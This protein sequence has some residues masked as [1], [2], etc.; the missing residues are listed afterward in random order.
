METE[1]SQGGNPVP[2]GT[3]ILHEE[4]NRP[5]ARRPHEVPHLG[6]MDN[7]SEEAKEEEG[8]SSLAQCLAL[9]FVEEER[10]GILSNPVERKTST[11]LEISQRDPENRTGL[12]EEN[13]NVPEARVEN[14]SDLSGNSPQG[15]HTVAYSPSG[16][17]SPL[18][19]TNFLS[20]K[21]RVIG[22]VAAE[23]AKAQA[24]L[25]VFPQA[26]NTYDTFSQTLGEAT[27]GTDSCHSPK[28][29]SCE[30]FLGSHDVSECFPGSHDVS[31]HHQ[32]AESATFR[33]E[34]DPSR[35]QEVPF[36]MDKERSQKMEATEG[37]VEKEPFKARE[38]DR[39]NHNPLTR[40]GEEA[41]ASAFD[42]PKTDCS[43]GEIKNL[44]VTKPN[45]VL[46]RRTSELSYRDGTMDDLGQNSFACTVLHLQEEED[47]TER[48]SIDLL[49]EETPVKHIKSNVDCR[50]SESTQEVLSTPVGPEPEEMDG[51]EL[52]DTEPNEEEGDLDWKEMEKELKTVQEKL[53]LGHNE[54]ENMCDSEVENASTNGAQNATPDLPFTP[55]LDT[56]CKGENNLALSDFSKNE[57][58]A[59]AEGFAFSFEELFS[60]SNRPGSDFGLSEPFVQTA[61]AKTLPSVRKSLTNLNSV[62]ENLKTQ[63]AIHHDF[64]QW[65]YN[66]FSD[67]AVCIFYSGQHDGQTIESG[68]KGSSEKDSGEHIGGGQNIRRSDSEEMY[69]FLYRSCTE[70]TASPDLKDTLD[71]QAMNHSNDAESPNPAP[72]L[73]DTT[74]TGPLQE[75]TGQRADYGTTGNIVQDEEK[76]FTQQPVSQHPSFPCQLDTLVSEEASVLSNAK[77]VQASHLKNTSEEDLH[78]EAQGSAPKSLQ[79]TAPGKGLS[80]THKE[81]TQR[82]L[83]SSSNA[84]GT[85]S[86]Q[87]QGTTMNLEKLQRHL[88]LP[89]RSVVFSGKEAGTDAPSPSFLALEEDR[90]GPSSPNSSL[91]TAPDT[92]FTPMPVS[93][94][95]LVPGPF[96]S[97]FSQPLT[98]MPALFS[99]PPHDKAFLVQ[100]SALDLDSKHATVLE[101]PPSPSQTS[102]HFFPKH[103][104]TPDPES[105]TPIPDTELPIQLLAAE[106]GS[107]QNSQ[108]PD[109]ESNSEQSLSL[110]PESNQPA[111]HSPHNFRFCAPKAHQPFQPALVT[112]NSSQIGEATATEINTS[113]LSQLPPFAIND[114]SPVSSSNIHPIPNG[115]QFS[116]QPVD[117]PVSN[118]LLKCMEGN[119]QIHVS[120]PVA[121]FCSPSKPSLHE[122]ETLVPILNAG[123]RIKE[124][125]V[126]QFVK[127]KEEIVPQGQQ[128]LNIHNMSSGSEVSLLDSYSLQNNASLEDPFS[129]IHETPD[130]VI[131]LSD[132]KSSSCA[133]TSQPLVESW[134]MP[135]AEEVR[136]STQSAPL[137]AFT[138]P[139][140]F[141][142]LGP[143]S[144][145]TTRQQTT[146]REPKRQQQQ[147][148]NA[149][150]NSGDKAASTVIEMM[151]EGSGRAFGNPVVERSPTMGQ[152]KEEVAKHPP[153]EKSSSCPGKGVLRLDPKE[154]ESSSKKQQVITKHRAKSKDWHRQGVRKISVATDNALGERFLILVRA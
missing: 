133:H 142:G 27:L 47:G 24:L 32:H 73:W 19:N 54:E 97:H 29:S 75:D 122:A 131:D 6:T 90:D 145:P 38:T 103:T 85:V 149:K 41:K 132:G 138:N 127:S 98:P 12:S 82:T 106:P 112:A 60:P 114:P 91:T 5:P 80:T 93:D 102:E 116:Q 79:S 36:G 44:D 4:S 78:E 123:D 81:S 99:A 105:P 33:E 146:S 13:V 15:E 59:E 136:D 95:S 113:L 9:L 21:P 37:A 134:K 118:L 40:D 76:D 8:I 107:N 28:D 69:R 35:D 31:E 2:Q 128:D 61:N 111:L 70:L 148:D 144:P 124:V 100:S 89:M 18:F 86:I 71:S 140:H 135:E 58:L 147:L 62:S 11:D 50:P 154:A 3:N 104:A 94:Q 52:L 143:P 110:A 126:V 129:S 7:I 16:C 56:L 42:L 14:N 74:A 68:R 152:R 101:P 67:Q 117:A 22:D 88:K 46:S 87:E 64:G 130:T 20:Q 121:S 151:T 96:S 49:Q 108:L 92:A 109:L 39:V 65:E 55:G 137:L 83:V 119:D 77:A 25:D 139:I 141:F 66:V 84:W 10:W 150:I 153:L 34:E 1:K 48:G 17:Q 115:N 53:D 120:N 63:P 125:S 72:P 26:L 57:S 45:G 51:A 23:Q 30:L 43:E